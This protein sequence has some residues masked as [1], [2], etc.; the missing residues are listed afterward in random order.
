MFSRVI[1]RNAPTTPYTPTSAAAA[2]RTT[3]SKHPVPGPAGT[4][5]GAESASASFQEALRQTLSR[6]LRGGAH[7]A[8]GFGSCAPNNEGCGT[9]GVVDGEGAGLS[10]FASGGGGSPRTDVG[11]SRSYRRDPQRQDQ[12]QRPSLLRSRSGSGLRQL[13]PS[14][15]P[16]VLDEGIVVSL[17][18]PPPL[19]SSCAQSSRR[20]TDRSE[21]ND[22]GNS[23][24]TGRRRLASQP[25]P[26]PDDTAVTGDFVVGFSTS[27]KK[28]GIA[29]FPLPVQTEL[30]GE[31][32]HTG[33]A[34]GAAARV[35]YAVLACQEDVDDAVAGA[36]IGGDIF[37]PDLRGE[38]VAREEKNE[39][40]IASGVVVLG[41]VE[42]Q[43]SWGLGL[44]QGEGLG[45]H[46]PDG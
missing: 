17:G 25:Q 35:A 23:C 26:F 15:D 6:A 41:G 46:Q 1:P 12:R 3:A 2:S 14:F 30:S 9:G 10:E 36:L 18:L 43:V 29:G 13:V 8:D 7:A 21:D 16:L 37:A 31:G 44:W 42:R 34:A 28:A 39:G 19:S 40:G 20:Y 11:G 32:G 22:N 5:A 33:V 27:D 24:A 38:A 45:D 4:P